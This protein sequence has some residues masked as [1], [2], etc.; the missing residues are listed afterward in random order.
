MVTAPY[1]FATKLAAFESRGGGDYLASHDLEDVIAV[2][3]GRPEI[4]EEIAGADQVLRNHLA[5][6]FAELLRDPDFESALPGHL[7]GDTA[8]QA[9]VPLILARISA[10]VGL[11]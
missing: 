3:D 4:T 8:S 5:Q 6:R 11:E 10:I 1:F 2:L 7:P 9:R